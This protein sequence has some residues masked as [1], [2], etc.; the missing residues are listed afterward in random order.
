MSFVF[1]PR[2]IPTVPVFEENNVHFPIHRVYCVGANY[3]DHVKEVGSKGRERPFFF[4][5]PADAVVVAKNGIEVPIPYALD[6]ENLNLEVELV[7]A[8]GKT[9]PWGK[10]IEPGEAMDYVWGF[11][12]GVEF[13]RR[14]WQTKVRESS[15][16]W[17]RSKGF[18]FSAVISELRPIYRAPEADNMELWLYVNDQLRQKGNTSHMIWSIPEIISELSSSWQLCAG[19]LIYTGTPAGT[20]PILPG[21]HF[22]GGISGVGIF[23]GKMGELS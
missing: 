5:K 21:Q 13:T 8:I 4:A 22:E 12:A 10:V 3:T 23:K 6:T 14:D 17:E 20:G 9:A 11:G 7:V 16:P 18:D 1:A 19:D 15:Q 2:S